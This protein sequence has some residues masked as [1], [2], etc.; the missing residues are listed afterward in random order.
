MVMIIH[1]EGIKIEK[2]ESENQQPVFY[3]LDEFVL[4]LDKMFKM[5]FNKS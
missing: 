3:K 5:G 2:Y 4:L 1:N